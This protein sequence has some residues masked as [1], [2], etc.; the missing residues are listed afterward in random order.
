LPHR[1]H[2]AANRPSDQATE[3]AH[4]Q[5]HRQRGER[6]EQHLRVVH[7]QPAIERQLE[8]VV[9]VGVK[10][11]ERPERKRRAHHEQCLDGSAP[12]DR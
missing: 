7:E 3:P 4:E 5:H 9:H 10:D 2:A 8:H 11:F 6:K 1:I 12:H